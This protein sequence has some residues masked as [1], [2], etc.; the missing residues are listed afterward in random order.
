MFDAQLLKRAL[1]NLLGNAVTHATEGTTIE[2]NIDEVDDQ[3]VSLAVSNRG[4]G[5]PQDKLGRVFER[6]FRVD[7][8]RSG[9]DLHHGL[10]LSIVAGIA[11]MHSGLAFAE[12]T[13]Q[14][15]RIGITLPQSAAIERPIEDNSHNADATGASALLQPDIEY[16]RANIVSGIN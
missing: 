15:T 16:V 5:I 11:Q 3:R 13:D 2:I 8:A 14:I 10:G 12:S 4:T 9:A 6:F 1:S 7:S